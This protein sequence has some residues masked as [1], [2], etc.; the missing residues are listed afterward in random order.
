MV[1]NPDFERKL[2]ACTTALLAGASAVGVVAERAR[3]NDVILFGISTI[4]LGYTS[5]YAA[6]RKNRQIPQRY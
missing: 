6:K 5:W 3:P 1:C 2:V 4:L